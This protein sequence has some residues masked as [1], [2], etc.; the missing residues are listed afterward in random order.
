MATEHVEQDKQPEQPKESSP[1][2]WNVTSRMEIEFGKENRILWDR[3]HKDYGK[4]SLQKKAFAPLVAK[5]KQSN[6]PKSE[7]ETA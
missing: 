4:N 6:M 2:G 5:L 1:S 3:N 7:P